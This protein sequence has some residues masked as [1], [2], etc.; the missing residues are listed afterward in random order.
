METLKNVA[1]IIID[2][3]DHRSRLELVGKM[4]HNDFEN[5]ART[6]FLTHGMKG[7][8]QAYGILDKLVG[9]YQQAGTRVDVMKKDDIDRIEKLLRGKYAQRQ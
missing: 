4:A 6:L 2:G 5:A 8:E 1:E 3:K 9:F 7:L